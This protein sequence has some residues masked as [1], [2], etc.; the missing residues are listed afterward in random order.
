M[1]GFGQ[2]AD[3]K[4]GSCASCAG[5]FVSVL[6]CRFRLSAGLR[7]VGVHRQ[8]CSVM[9]A[10]LLGKAQTVPGQGTPSSLLAAPCSLRSSVLVWVTA[11]SGGAHTGQLFLPQQPF[12]STCTVT[13]QHL[14]HQEGLWEEPLLHSV[15][16]PLPRAWG[17][18]QEGGWGQPHRGC[19]CMAPRT[20]RTMGAVG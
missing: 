8:N 15:S 19:G 4:T 16:L 18:Q 10:V 5:L 6:G 11:V 3:A 12:P 13:R 2:P 1:R 14:W 7:A 9:A 17:G 20:W